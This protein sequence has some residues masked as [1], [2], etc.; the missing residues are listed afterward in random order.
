M[1]PPFKQR[2]N[3]DRPRRPQHWLLDSLLSSTSMLLSLPHE[4]HT[5]STNLSLALMTG[6]KTDH[7]PPSTISA[8]NLNQGA[9][10]FI[11]TNRM[12][13]VQMQSPSKWVFRV[14]LISQG[15]MAILQTKA[16]EHGTGDAARDILASSSR[17]KFSSQVHK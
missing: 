17:L 4:T 11:Q 7:M 9:S 15:A 1:M 5:K 2:T 12:S 6:L 14:I 10:L 13:S 3:S 16:R 8:Q